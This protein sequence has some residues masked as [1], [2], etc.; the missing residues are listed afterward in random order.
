M[1]KASRSKRERGEQDAEAARKAAIAAAQKPEKSLPVFWL[2]IGF[3]VIAGIAALILT[4]PDKK[5]DAAVNAAKKA[6]VYADVQAKGELKS[7]QGNDAKD[8]AVGD[9][10]P[11]FSGKNIKN[12]KVS[13]GPDAGQPQFIAVMAH[14]CPHCNNEVPKIVEWANDGGLPDNVKMWAISTS[15]K[16]GSPNFPPAEWLAKEKW[17]WPALVDDE[18]GTASLALGGD[19]FPF[20]VFVNADG[21]V[22]KRF[23]GEMDIDELDKAV[24]AIAKTKVP[25]AK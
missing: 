10:I 18:L 21:T 25:A 7:F 9:K 23:S 16:Q 15:A 3:I 5:E 2:V 8:T 19:G 24:K 13:F 17:T 22:Y 1:G 4:K 6:P 11:E 14:W 12:E 20:L